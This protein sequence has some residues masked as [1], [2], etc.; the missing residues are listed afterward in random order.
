MILTVRAERRC[1][2]TAN[3]EIAARRDEAHNSSNEGICFHRSCQF[4]D[5]ARCPYN[6]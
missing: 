6:L 3:R 2:N 1:S 4:L 5:K